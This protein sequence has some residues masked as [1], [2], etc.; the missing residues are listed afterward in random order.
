MCLLSTTGGVGGVLVVNG[1]YVYWTHGYTG[2]AQADTVY[3]VSAAGGSVATYSTAGIVNQISPFGLYLGTGAAEIAQISGSQLVVISTGFHN[4]TLDVIGGVAEASQGYWF[5]DLRDTSRQ[6]WPASVYQGTNTAPAY[7]Y[8]T[9]WPIGP[10]ASLG[11]SGPNVWWVQP[12]VG[13]ESNGASTMTGLSN[14]SNLAVDQSYLWGIAGSGIYRCG[15]TGCPAATLWASNQSSPASIYSDG[16]TAYWT[17]SGNGEVMKCAVANA[18]CT[19][20]PTGPTL[21]AQGLVNPQGVAVDSTAVYVETANA[22][23]KI[24]K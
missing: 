18:I 24:A 10:M 7:T 3:R 19:G 16:T 4:N 9:T 17:N 20:S 5:T 22:V 23:Y 1:G 6:M 21:V 15:G 2:N 12:G 13:I 11:P 8:N 14:V